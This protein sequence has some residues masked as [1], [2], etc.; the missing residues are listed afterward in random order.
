[1]MSKRHRC[2][3]GLDLRKHARCY[4]CKPQ[5]NG[6]EIETV[7][8]VGT[9]TSSWWCGTCGVVH[10]GPLCPNQTTITYHETTA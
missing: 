10:F 4:L 3:H 6:I 5:S 1:M 8:F 7:P 9:S 2:P